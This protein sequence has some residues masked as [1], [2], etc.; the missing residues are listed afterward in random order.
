MGNATTPMVTDTTTKV[1]VALVSVMLKLLLTFVSS[2]TLFFY[3]FSTCSGGDCAWEGRLVH[4]YCIITNCKWY[5]SL[6][7]S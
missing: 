3:F 4:N 5:L 2:S 7:G 1:S 6:D